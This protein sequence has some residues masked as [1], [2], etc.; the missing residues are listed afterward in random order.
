M[1]Q[2]LKIKNYAII[3]ST[4][5]EFGNGLNIVTGETGAGKSILLGA[6]GLVLGERS[7]SK[8]IK[9]GADKLVVEACFNTSDAFIN[10]LLIDNDLDVSSHLI[11]RR[12]INANGKSRAFVNDTPVGLQL[13]KEIGVQLIDIVSQHQ[14]LQLY[15]QRIQ[16][17]LLDA[18]AGNLLLVQ[19]YQE[20]FNLFKL[21]EKNLNA[22]KEKI[23]Q[24]IQEESYLRYLIDEIEELSLVPNEED[25][26]ESE[27]A[28]LSNADQIQQLCAQG[29]DLIVNAEYNV[30][31][32][33]NVIV[34][35][36]QF[37]AKGIEPL[38]QLAKRIQSNIV[39]L[40]DIS[41]E[42]T[43]VGMD[44][45][46]NPQEL[47][48]KEQRLGKIM[49]LLKKHRVANTVALMEQLASKKSALQEIDLLNNQIADSEAT[50]IKT[51]EICI[52]LANK[53]HSSRMLQIPNFE[54]E[55]EQLLLELSIPH[56]RFKIELATI[57]TAQLSVFGINKINYFFSA[58]KGTSLSPINQVA[59]GGEM[60]RLM[61]SLKALVA[62]KIALPSI[63]FDEIDTGISGEAA[64]KVGV[65][66]KK[67]ANQQ[68]IIAITHLPQIAG[69]A[70]FHFLVNKD[71]STATVQTKIVLLDKEQR[72]VE[73]ARMISGENAG[74]T[75][76][77]AASELIN[78][79]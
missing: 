4:E 53:L 7:D 20:H 58:N 44:I 29:T 72:V 21:Q 3:H 18:Y 34:S 26:L 77:K 19:D 71:Q 37:A 12:E 62:E 24:A 67:L 55:I 74:E 57:E 52:Q 51:K 8:S 59:S 79:Q 2:S 61:L 54:K 78:N 48:L 41:A 10:A 45:V 31:D 70:D 14:T 27:I 22:L 46:P 38:E 65:V 49:N 33:L 28:K 23:A 64:L 32:Q 11:L 73:I 47:E 16:F 42:L 68:Q 9:P 60:S 63:V 76:L 25:I 50:F 5:I 43:A 17:Q 66:M 35:A 40:K 30:V 15:D 39:D 36:I 13:L 6:L 69:K 75:I 56:A 1:L